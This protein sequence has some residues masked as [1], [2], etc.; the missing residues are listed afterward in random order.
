MA[1]SLRRGTTKRCEAFHYTKEPGRRASGA[2]ALA[3]KRSVGHLAAA[4]LVGFVPAAVL[5]ANGLIGLGRFLALLVDTWGGPELASAHLLRRRQ[6]GGGAGRF[7][8]RHHRRHR[9][10]VHHDGVAQAQRSRLVTRGA[11]GAEATHK[12]RCSY[13]GGSRVGRVPAFRGHGRCVCAAVPGATDVHQRPL[14]K[15][16]P[17]AAQPSR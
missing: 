9:L 10:F 14:T 4:L 7:G 5:H 1:N 6:A 12:G 13:C 3:S 15:P 8:F 16:L 2:A 17:L 11:L